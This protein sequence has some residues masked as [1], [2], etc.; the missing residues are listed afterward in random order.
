M[1]SASPQAGY[2]TLPFG[3]AQDFVRAVF[4]AHGYSPADA[5]D[6]ADVVLRADLA[7]PHPAFL[8]P[9]PA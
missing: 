2:R 4:V 6:I 1:S 3:A 9:S 7:L 5:A 8:D